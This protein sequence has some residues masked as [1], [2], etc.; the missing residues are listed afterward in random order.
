MNYIKQ[1]RFFWDKAKRHSLGAGEIA[2]YFYILECSNVHDWENPVLEPNATLQ[3]ATGVK[4]FNTLK[5]IRNKLQQAGLL[6][7]KTKNGSGVV[8]YDLFNADK[9]TFSKNEKVVEEVTAKVSDEVA[10]KVPD[11]VGGKHLLDNKQ[12]PKQKEISNHAHLSHA[13]VV[14]E[15]IDNEIFLEQSAMALNLDSAE[16]FKDFI[17]EK[18]AV[19]AI[20]GDS[21]KYPLG[22]VK[23]ILIQDFKIY[24]EKLKRDERKQQQQ[25]TGRNGANTA[26]IVS[27]ADSILQQYQHQNNSGGDTG[28]H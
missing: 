18:M 14:R 15:T 19:M 2:M 24:R 1:I 10:A 7:F 21:T 17:T 25:N 16:P 5:E 9:Q 12:K 22:T 6:K 13:D 26:A 8:E 23:R 27:A 4:S 11:K 3:H 28:T 20:T